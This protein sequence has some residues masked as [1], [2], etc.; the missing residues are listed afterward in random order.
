MKPRRLRAFTLVEIVLAVALLG[1]LLLAM[2]VFIF[3][4]GEIWGRNGEQRLFDQ[5]VRAV[6][7]HVEGLLRRA[8]L[9][10]GAL[11]G[12]GAP[13]S[14]QEIRLENGSRE[15]LL[16]FDLPD[17][18]RVLPWPR[19]P[20]PDVVC[21]LAAQDGRGLLLYWHSRL[22]TRFEEDPPRVTVL[23]PFG[24]SLTYDYYQADFKSWQNQTRLQQDREGRWQA[25]QRITL[26]FVHGKMTAET[27][28]AL[29]APTSALP[30][31]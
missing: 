12:G 23:S 14:A 8:A 20:L 5:H 9:T 19:A 16:T 6:T 11:G 27:T 17:G 21:S 24:V 13:V 7:R 10:P 2:N 1:G 28:V 18:D 25:P 29:P 22:E 26:R 31:F 30:A 4:M 15:R 3:S